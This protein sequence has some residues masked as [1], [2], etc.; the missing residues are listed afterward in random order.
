MRV[1]LTWSEMRVGAEIAVTRRC[2][3]LS[4]QSGHS[5]GSEQIAGLGMDHEVEGVWAEIAV[6]KWLGVYWPG[7]GLKK[8][9]VDAG[10]VEV[11]SIDH[12]KKRLLLHPKDQDGLPFVLVLVTPD[13]LPCVTLLGWVWGR[14][15]K[16]Q[17]FWA[18]PVGGRPAYFVDSGI[19]RPM[20][21][22]QSALSE[23]VAA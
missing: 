14:E 5:Y 9:T 12:R 15:G 4:G 23:G 21:E 8:H 16:V 19:L 7:L 3:G 6:A 18:D 11:R 20:T 17:K 2:M 1:A 10:L 22:L 13:D